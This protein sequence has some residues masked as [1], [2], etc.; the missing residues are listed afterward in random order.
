MT[1]LLTL[2]DASRHPAFRAWPAAQ[3]KHRIKVRQDNPEESDLRAQLPHYYR[4]FVDSTV[5]NTVENEG[6]CESSKDCSRTLKASLVADMQTRLR[7]ASQRDKID[8]G[9][10]FLNLVS[11]TG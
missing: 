2:A 4:I 10:I 1:S 9:L 6:L 11:P 8:V 7:A 5:V 3:L